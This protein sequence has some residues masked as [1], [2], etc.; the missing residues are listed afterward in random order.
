MNIGQKRSRNITA[1]C[2][3]LGYSRQAYYQQLQ[4]EEQQ[5]LKSELI[6]QEVINIRNRQKMVGTRKLLFMLQPFMRQ[7]KIEIGRD[8]LFTL[9]CDYP[10]QLSRII[11]IENTLI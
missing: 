2:S 4:S 10:E 11:G 8:A 7:H 1:L 5:A 9:L 3:L 6:V